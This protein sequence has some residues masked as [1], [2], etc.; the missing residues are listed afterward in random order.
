[1]ERFF[2]DPRTLPRGN[3]ATGARNRLETEGW[4]PL[5]NFRDSFAHYARMAIA[6][7]V[8]YWCLF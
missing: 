2:G 7:S 3:L 4:R 6:A 1:V 8:A 5:G